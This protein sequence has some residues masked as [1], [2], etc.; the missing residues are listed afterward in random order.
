M[1]RLILQCIA[2]TMIFRWKSILTRVTMWISD[3]FRKRIT[4]WLTKRIIELL[5]RELLDCRLIIYDVAKIKM[6]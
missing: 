2:V 5:S 1:R 3:F 6:P 4:K